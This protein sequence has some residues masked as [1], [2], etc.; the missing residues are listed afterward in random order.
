MSIRNQ[1]GFTLQKQFGNK[2]KFGLWHY[3]LGPN[4]ILATKL[5]GLTFIG[6][7]VLN[8]WNRNKQLLIYARRSS[9]IVD[10]TELKGSCKVQCT[11][12]VILH[13]FRDHLP[14]K[15]SRY[16]I[17][18]LRKEQVSPVITKKSDNRKILVFITK[19][20]KGIEISHI[21][22]DFWYIQM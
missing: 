22:E 2:M 8:K 7:G 10:V 15:L 21:K 17:N 9:S 16:V 11:T 3:F 14:R 1:Y 12:K 6:L 20:Q 19:S 13:D 4:L 18:F 5:N